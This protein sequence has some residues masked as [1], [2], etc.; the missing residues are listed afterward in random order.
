M[1]I[2]IALALFIGFN[3]CLVFANRLLLF[4]EAPLRRVV[5]DPQSCLQSLNVTDS[6]VL[7]VKLSFYGGAILTMPLVI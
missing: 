2:R 1:L 4:L 5:S 6:F 3:I 7:A